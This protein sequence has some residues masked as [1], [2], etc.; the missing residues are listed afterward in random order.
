MTQNPWGRPTG[1]QQWGGQQQW[2]SPADPWGRPSGQAGWGTSQRSGQTGW[3][4][5]SWGAPQQQWPAPYGQQPPL[6]RG[7][8][9]RRRNPLVTLIKVLL[10]LGVLGFLG[11]VLLGAVLSSVVSSISVPEPTSQATT[12][13]PD[14]PWDPSANPATAS[15]GPSASAT[16]GADASPSG[17]DVANQG[18]YQNEDYQVPPAD[19]TPP[20]LPEPET[21]EEATDLLKAN[22]LYATSVPKPV[23]CEMGTL[24]LQ[25]ASR[26]QLTDH[27]NQMTACLMRVWEQPLA[28][29]GFQAVRP[30]V[31]VYSGSV[32]SKCGKLPS[33]NAVY[34]GADQQVYYAADLPRTIPSSLRGSRYIS[35]AVVAHEFGHAVQA[36]S[37]ILISEAAWEEKSSKSTANQLSR[38]L[39][40]QADCFAGQFLGSIQQSTAMT[41]TELANVSKLFYSIGDD[42]LTGRP[43]YEGNH[44]AGANRQS[45]TSVGLQST[46]VGACNTFTADA[47]TV[48]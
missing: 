20:P 35:E 44:G 43:G 14:S 17:G 21:Y 40:M 16:P 41:P 24:D 36:R 29:A 19:L 25:T 8:P 6:G 30:S 48:R 9:P 1:Q 31:T 10:V 18:S 3:G 26:A 11:L 13:G 34:C 39:E 12:R 46:K 22:P 27:F 7:R 2:P 38:R 15:P 23:R 28:D 5:T 45:W 37:A 33:R 4:Q 32:T 42:V 47:N